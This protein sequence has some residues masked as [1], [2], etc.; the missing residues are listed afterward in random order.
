MEYGRL[1]KLQKW[2]LNR[3]LENKGNGISRDE[4]REFFGKRLP[5]KRHL[6]EAL[7][8]STFGTEGEKFDWNGRYYT[9]KKELISTRS[10]EASVSRSFNNLIKREFLT[11]KYHYGQCFLTEK[12]FLKVNER[13]NCNIVNT[14]KNYIDTINKVNEEKGESFKKLVKD[15]KK[16][17]KRGKIPGKR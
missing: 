12:G 1:S 17:K 16:I 5:P 4:S 14:Y 7:H 10:I 11:E 3:C 2:I 9:P 8:E 15:L 6:C 13:T